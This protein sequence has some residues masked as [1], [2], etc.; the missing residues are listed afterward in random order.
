[1]MSGR[2]PASREQGDLVTTRRTHHWAALLIPSLALI[3]LLATTPPAEAGPRFTLKLE[4]VTLH[5]ALLRLRQTTGWEISA[6][7]GEGSE[8]FQE[9]AKAPK[10][11]FEWKNAPVG[12]ILREVAETFKLSPHY[13]GSTNVWLRHGA[14]AVDAGGRTIIREGIAITLESLDQRELRTLKIGSNRPEVSRYLYATFRLRALAGDPDVMY[15]VS[16][17]TSRDD[18]GNLLR[19]EEGSVSRRYGYSGGNWPDEWTARIS[20]GAFDPEAKRL[21]SITGSVIL[22]RSLR[23]RRVEVSLP[24]D[25]KQSETKALGVS[26]KVKE[27]RVPGKASPA[28]RKSDPTLPGKSFPPSG[29]SPGQAILQ[30]EASWPQ[31]MEVSTPLSMDGGGGGGLAPWIRLKSGKLVRCYGNQTSAEVTDTGMIVAQLRY[32]ASGL[33]EP[34]VAIVWDLQTRQDPTKRAVFEFTDIPLPFALAE[35]PKPKPAAIKRNPARRSPFFDANGGILVTD[36]YTGKQRLGAG[37]LMIGLARRE[38]VKFGA[39]RWVKTETNAAGQVKLPNLRPGVYRVHR[40]FRP[41]DDQGALKP[42]PGEWENASVTVTVEAKKELA[43]PP[44]RHQG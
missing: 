7:R 28:P 18:R 1:M 13:N 6:D 24:L 40:L 39:I 10:A 22:Y 23:H 25:P 4:N 3:V 44:L 33:R 27:F 2:H 5:Q 17:V 26:I 20:L 34:A 41:R 42:L 32:V 30:I 43:L 8:G 37:E 16:Q 36:V 21:A 35:M 31:E 12:A 11:S 19:P 38:G 15:G 29:E 14:P 9:P